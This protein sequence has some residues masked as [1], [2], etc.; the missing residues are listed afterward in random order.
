MLNI[1]QINTPGIIK[2]LM[3]Y[4]L[5]CILL[6]SIVSS[7]Y[8]TFVVLSSD[9]Y[10]I[11]VHEKPYVIELDLKYIERNGERFSSIIVT[12]LN[13]TTEVEIPY[14]FKP[15]GI[16][17]IEYG[18]KFY[19]RG[20]DITRLNRS[21]RI[22]LISR[23][24]KGEIKR[25]EIT[26]K[27]I[28]MSSLVRNTT[29]SK[30]IVFIDPSVKISDRK[31]SGW[32]YRAVQEGLY[33]RARYEWNGYI[34]HVYFPTNETKDVEPLVAYPKHIPNAYIRTVI[35][36]YGD[37]RIQ[38]EQKQLLDTRNSVLFLKTGYPE[39]TYVGINTLSTELNTPAYNGRFLWFIRPWASEDISNGNLGNLRNRTLTGQYSYKCNDYFKIFYNTTRYEVWVWLSSNKDVS[40]VL[41]IYL[42]NEKALDQVINLESGVLYGYG[43]VVRTDP[44]E[45][46]NYLPSQDIYVSVELL[47]VS[48][49][50][51]KIF[52][53][54]IAVAKAYIDE[55]T[56]NYYPRLYLKGLGDIFYSSYP[57]EPFDNRYMF[58]TSGEA[59]FSF[60][61]FDNIFEPDY[62]YPY[63]YIYVKSAS[64]QKY[65]RYV[66]LYINGK[67]L[68]RKLAYNPS[69][70]NGTEGVR[71]AVF[72][73]DGSIDIFQE[74]LSSMKAGVS[75]II[76]IVIEGFKKPEY[77]NIDKWFIEYGVLSVKARTIIVGTHPHES[78]PNDEH[79][80]RFIGLIPYRYYNGVQLW[81]FQTD[82]KE[83]KLMISY[84]P[85][86]ADTLYPA[87]ISVDLDPSSKYAGD[88][89]SS[90]SWGVGRIEITLDITSNRGITPFSFTAWGAQATDNPRKPEE[91]VRW[92]LWFVSVAGTIIS[93]VSDSWIINGVTLLSSILSYPTEY[94]YGSIIQCNCYNVEDDEILCNLIY[95]PG[96]Y[97]FRMPI[98]LRVTIN[99]S[100][101]GGSD[102]WG[103][104]D[105]LNINYEVNMLVSSHYEITPLSSIKNG[106]VS[107]YGSITIRTVSP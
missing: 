44:E 88:E 75:P 6:L 2:D 7:S 23:I 39:A 89:Y 56:G 19:Y 14:M 45:P 85:P 5:L 27:T 13:G 31:Y 22:E 64:D 37:G 28:Q 63:I 102:S 11:E 104:N 32:Y 53:N 3:N 93:F 36:K 97:D 74:I 60:A 78:L 12:V 46:G 86:T 51:A 15:I 4:M 34:I 20:K 26:Y 94:V 1:S 57:D 55:T 59:V 18:Y 69:I 67:L 62:P 98:T 107:D 71:Y 106:W 24:E 52:L 30:I 66:S 105:W 17:R 43:V 72:D 92:G 87:E 41:R 96:Y 61:G 91:A 40:F 103:D 95:D 80:A 58:V 77:S 82:I 49:P 73:I 21:E 29:S 16:D 65:D 47:S 35:Y 50:A 100:P 8:S 42:N 25:D 76:K 38:Y 70:P 54:T 79:T 84:F 83:H 81:N 10:L 101:S 33:E 68:A 99:P 90:A 48:D 9:E